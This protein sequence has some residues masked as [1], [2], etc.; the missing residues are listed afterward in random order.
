MGFRGG[1][2]RD[3]HALSHNSEDGLLQCHHLIPKK[4]LQDVGLNPDLGPAIQ[5][6]YADHKDTETWGKRR[7]ARAA[8]ARIT[9]R[10]RRGDYDGTLQDGIADVRSLAGDR[11]D[12]AIAE[13]ERYHAGW[14]PKAPASIGGAPPRGGAPMADG[15][16][17][18]TVLVNRLS[19]YVEVLDRHTVAIQQ[20]YDQACES[21]ANLQRVWGGEAAQEFYTRFGS[22]T[23]ALERYLDGARGM[24]EI[25]EERLTSLRQADR[26]G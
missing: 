8:L 5:M 13:A 25:L 6:T 22:T 11:Y 4:S 16:A 21:L 20:A 3:V 17:N 2:Y 26:P 9:E 18:V 14:R 23:E 10:L 24:R 19:H 7:K 1:S 12:G 15:Q